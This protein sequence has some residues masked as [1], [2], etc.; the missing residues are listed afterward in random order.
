MPGHVFLVVCFSQYEAELSA[1]SGVKQQLEEVTSEK[2]SLEKSLSSLRAEHQVLQGLRDGL[3]T[4]LHNL[5][6]GHSSEPCPAPT[7]AREHTLAP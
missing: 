1:L 5:Q 6:V 2:G 3:E 7:A 4:E